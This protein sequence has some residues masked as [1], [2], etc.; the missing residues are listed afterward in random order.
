MAAYRV[1]DGQA[2]VFDTVRLLATLAVFLGHATKPDVLFDVD[3]A[4][5]GRATIPVF[6]MLSGYLTAATMARGG[7]FWQRAARRYLGLW[8]VVVP[9]IPILFAADLWLISQGSVLLENAKFDADVSAGTVLRET[10]Q[11]LTYSGEYWRLDTV[12][13]G[14]FGNQAY[15]T[16]EYIMAYSVATAALYLLDG[17][18]RVV[19]L[20]LG[21]LIAGPTVVLLSPLWM[22]G[23]GAFE[24][25][26]RCARAVEAEAAGCPAPAWPAWL[27]RCGAPITLTGLAL[28]ATV[29]LT[30]VGQAAYQESKSWASYDWRQHLGMAKR[31]A[32]Q[33][34]LVPGVFLAILG[35]RYMIRWCPGPGIVAACRQAGRY[36]LPVYVFHFSM[37]YVA[38]SL[39]PGYRPTW[40]APDP[41][42]MMALA[43]ALTLLLSWLTLRFCRPVADRLIARIL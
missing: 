37:I 2:V 8:F 20:A 9:A 24:V 30:G 28:V 7:V 10:V 23:V 31:F 33:W 36:T 34:L 35:S 17:W 16:V 1:P 12:S 6:L 43:L 40:T 18:R 32:W 41:Y 4:L 13:Q 21:G 3:V 26:R 38:R 14:L 39:I 22:A 29:E 27:R 11:A 5:L 15:W 19:A 25:H 42:L